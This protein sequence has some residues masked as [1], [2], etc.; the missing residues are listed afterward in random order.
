MWSSILVLIQFALLVALNLAG[1][2]AEPLLD[3]LTHDQLTSGADH[4]TSGADSP[5]PVAN[6]HRASRADIT[7]RT[8][9]A[10]HPL[11]SSDTDR[12]E[13]LRYAPQRPPPAAWLS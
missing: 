1:A 10:A 11:E 7:P 3:A 5:N 13:I 4:D 6:S 12:L 8:W 2:P 9:R